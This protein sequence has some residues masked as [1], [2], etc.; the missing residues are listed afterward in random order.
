MAGHIHF[1]VNI[2]KRSKG[3]SAVAAAAYR[4]RM[5]ILNERTGETWDYSRKASDV[6]FSGIV[7]PK[8]APEWMRDRAQLWNGV[9]RF[10]RYKTAQLSRDIIIALPH[11]LSLDE[12]KRMLTDYVR[13]Q[14]TRK[15]YVADVAIHK[16]DAAGDFRNIHA[17]VQVTMRPV[18]GDT[19]AAKKEQFNPKN[20][21]AEQTTKWR[22][23]YAKI[24][25]H[26]L[27]KNGFSA[28][29]D[30]RSYEEQGV[31]QVPTFHIGKDANKLERDGIATSRG[32]ALRAIQEANLLREEARALE[33]EAANANTAARD[34]AN[35]D[36]PQIERDRP[37]QVAAA[38]VAETQT[39]L[40]RMKADERAEQIETLRAFGRRRWSSMGD[41]LRGIF[42]A[43]RSLA[44]T[45]GGTLFDI[46]KGSGFFQEKAAADYR[47]AMQPQRP[48]RV[49]GK[50]PPD[51]PR[52]EPTKPADRAQERP[53]AETLEQLL[54]RK[55]AENTKRNPLDALRKGLHRG[56]PSRD[57]EPDI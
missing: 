34:R 6:L 54:A 56:K 9:E 45:M 48:E 15:G 50:R 55:K 14:F 7:A 30:H 39:A 8:D 37:V 20:P 49:E 12:N 51:K 11:E 52:Q 19:F 32:D 2:V 13:E 1:R 41:E 5:E 31:E 57:N 53:P 17:H 43:V 26:Y 23:A 40:D 18:V 44:T 47:A 29:L 22:E 3:H 25:N 10:E 27:V 42:A 16:P 24:G 4:A 38:Q 28:R 35:D 33:L 21:E 36:A 46:V